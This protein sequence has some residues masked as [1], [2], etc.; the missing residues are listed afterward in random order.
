MSTQAVLPESI[1]FLRVRRI[2][3]QPIEDSQRFVSGLFR[4][5]ESCATAWLPNSCDERLQLSAAEVRV[6]S[7]AHV[8]PTRSLDTLDD[9]LAAGGGETLESC[10][11]LGPQ[12][13]IATIRAAGLRGRG[14]AGFPTGIK[15]AGLAAAEGAR[16][17]AVVNAAEGE[18]GTFKDR[19]II[20]RNPYQVVEGLAAAAYAVGADSAFIGIKEKSTASIARI[21]TATA[22]LSAAGLIGDLSVT[23]VPG[24]DD[25]L[26]GEEKGLLEV[27]EERI[28]CRGC[29]HRTCKASSRSPVRSPVLRS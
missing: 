14:G 1:W 18:P 26:F 22:E 28:P 9:Y 23:V 24:P 21:E 16:K 25:Y 11:K 10:R 20:R 27:I 17:Y 5:G 19:A 6:P 7:V 13:V 4:P 15:W 12:G 3:L 8:L 2:R 29:I